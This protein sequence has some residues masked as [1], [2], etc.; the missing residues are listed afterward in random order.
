MIR[1]NILSGVAL[2]SYT[3]TFMII[4]YSKFYV[5]MTMYLIEICLYGDKIGPVFKNGW[6]CTDMTNNSPRYCNNSAIHMKCCHSC[7]LYLKTST[8]SKP[9]S[10]YTNNV[11]TTSSTEPVSTSSVPPF[12]LGVDDQCQSILGAGSFLCRV[13]ETKSTYKIFYPNDKFNNVQ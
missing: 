6:T 3:D 12:T 8:A 5:I 10:T 9:S 11:Q 2:L 4:H 7:A 13:S 1:R